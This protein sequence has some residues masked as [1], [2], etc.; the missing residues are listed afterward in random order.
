MEPTFDEKISIVFII[1]SVILTALLGWTIYQDH[2]K[3]EDRKMGK[4][5][6]VMYYFIKN[7][8]YSNELSKTRLTEMVYLA[9]W[10]SALTYGRQITNINWFFDHYGPYV[11]DVYDT[12]EN[13]RIFTIENTF[14]AFG[15]PKQI[16][17]LSPGGKPQDELSDEEKAILD[18]VIE[19]TKY[20]NWTDFL[21]F[22]YSTYPIEISQRYSYLDLVKLATDMNLSLSRRSECIDADHRFRAKAVKKRSIG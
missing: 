8:P 16:I 22:V 7:Y 21:N 13:S 20:L 18:K 11:I 12:A 17:R 2:K 4:L 1:I 9:D 5:I 3:I 19:D 14:S 15:Y 10:Y 6:S